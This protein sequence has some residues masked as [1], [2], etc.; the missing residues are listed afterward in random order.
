MTIDTNQIRDQR[1]FQIINWIG[2]INQLA[3]TRGNQLLTRLN[4]PFPQFIML[5]HFSYR[6]NESKTVSAVAKAMQQPQPGVTKTI[7]R[8]ESNGYL[9][10]VPDPI[11]GRV[12]A[13]KL[14]ASGKAIHK[15][16]VSI[17][18]CDLRATFSDWHG[19]D[20]DRIFG[21]LDKLKTHLEDHR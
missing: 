15:K 9:C 14:T 1:Q 13:V 6:P 19:S 5:N 7:Q 2:I 4:L 11:D 16:A 10:A 12:K 3:S 17:I 18:Q 8:L 21:L 20:L